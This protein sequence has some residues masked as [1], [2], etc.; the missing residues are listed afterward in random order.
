MVMPTPLLTALVLCL[1]AGILQAQGRDVSH[2]SA[3]LG[4]LGG[5]SGLPRLAQDG[6]WGRV[7]YAEAQLPKQFCQS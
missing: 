4:A 3:G 6:E 7:P 1:A 2:P 5:H